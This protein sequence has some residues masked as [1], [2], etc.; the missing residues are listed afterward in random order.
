MSCSF[1]QFASSVKER[2]ECGGLTIYQSL[3]G[4]GGGSI[5]YGTDRCNI[6]FGMDSGGGTL[7]PALH[8]MEHGWADSGWIRLLNVRLRDMGDSFV[9][10]V[11]VEAGAL[12]R[13]SGAAAR[14][15]P[16]WRSKTAFRRGF[17]SSSS[18][19]AGMTDFPHCM[20]EQVSCRPHCRGY[21]PILPHLPTMTA[22]LRSK[23]PQLGQQHHYGEH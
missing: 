13:Y 17:S 14:L 10:L 16:F 19:S 1:L 21:C 11:V 20:T 15:C 23:T 4:F 9:Q 7:P 3:L 18:W 22:A 5:Q 8:V 2:T 12:G 6:K